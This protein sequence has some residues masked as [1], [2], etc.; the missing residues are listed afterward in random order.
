M[1]LSGDNF[2]FDPVVAIIQGVIFSLWIEY[3]IPYDFVSLVYRR[4]LHG[5]ISFE[6]L[7]H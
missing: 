4:S 7:R 5:G 6:Q 3:P 1:N 2:G